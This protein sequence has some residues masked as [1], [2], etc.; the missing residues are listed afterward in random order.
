MRFMLLAVFFLDFFI[1]LTPCTGQADNIGK[2][3]DQ[4]LE[5]SGAPGVSVSI[6]RKGQHQPQ[7]ITAG[8]ACV[9]NDVQ[10]TRQ[11]VM[12][13]GSVTKVFTGV[14]IKMLIEEGKLQYDTPMSRFFP[15]FPQAEKITIL[16]MLTHTSGLP[17][18]LMLEPMH[19]NF[20]KAWKPEEILAMVAKA[21]LDFAPGTRA[22]YSNTGFLVLGMIIEKLTGATYFQAIMPRIG[23]PLGM[24][25]LYYGDDTT[26]IPHESCG[27][28]KNADGTLRKPMLASMIPPFATGDLLVTSNDLVRLVNV[29]SLLK[30][31]LLDKPRAKPYTLKDGKLA[32]KYEHFLDMSY[33]REFAETFFIFRF[34]DRPLAVIGKLGAFPGF[35]GC[36][37][38]DPETE[39]AVAVTTNLET[40][41]MEAMQLGVRILEDK[42][43]AMDR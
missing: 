34:H 3:V 27:Y 30:T 24:T 12:K 28:S 40:A 36:F 23:A 17:E 2:Y 21:P 7:T 37:L 22:K 31:N 1:F 29:D 38:Y 6:M 39:F 41:T 5:S 16:N 43:R 14:R 4:F 10:V 25:T 8:S 13:I 18:M 33:D 19:S 15:D 11:C 26:I 42:K 20:C 9:E 35:T 32:K